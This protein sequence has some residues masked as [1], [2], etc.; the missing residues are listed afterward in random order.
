M[1]GRQMNDKLERISNEAVVNLLG[2]YP[3]N[4]LGGLRIT[5]VPVE[6]RIQYFPN[7]TRNLYLYTSLLGWIGQSEKL[8]ALRE[9]AR[10]LRRAD[11]PAEYKSDVV[12]L[13]LMSPDRSIK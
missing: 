13:V 12:S 6:I 9:I 3:G 11:V 8:Q 5:G 10:N 4:F 7:R 2:F 1:V